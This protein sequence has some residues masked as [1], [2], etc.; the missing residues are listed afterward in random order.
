[1]ARKRKHVRKSKSGQVEK[2]MAELAKI[3]SPH[4]ILGA[5]NKEYKKYPKL[6]KSDAEYEFWVKC[7]RST[8]NLSSGMEKWLEEMVDEEG[9]DE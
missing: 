3:A 6:S 9:D 5:L 1:M 8:A 7:E 4:T 2:T